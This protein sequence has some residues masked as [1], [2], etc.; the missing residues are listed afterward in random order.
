M[1]VVTYVPYFQPQVDL[2]S[3]EL[4]G[5]EALAGG[6]VGQGRKLLPETMWKKAEREGIQDEL[7]TQLLHQ[8]F[9]QLRDW[10][11]R[12]YSLPVV[13]VG[14]SVGTLSAAGPFAAVYY[15]VNA[16]KDI[17]ADRI[18]L[19]IRE[20]GAGQ[21]SRQSLDGNLRLLCRKGLRLEMLHSRPED[22]EPLFRGIPLHTLK[23]GAGLAEQA[24]AG[25][26]G[27]KV[28]RDLCQWCREC[29]IRLVAEGVETAGQAEALIRAGCFYGQGS[30]TSRPLT[31]KKF[32][33]RY[34]KRSGG[35]GG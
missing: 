11:K 19:K 2:R 7:E 4:T 33:D 21:A 14:V 13:S 34:L 31:V 25:E 12:G 20:A 22:P 6:V 3:G 24:E 8:V 9:C 32:E 26:D 29:G 30:W 16:H 35:K 18:S 23:L 15:L 17:P 5:V 27:D 1:P 28:I 10:K